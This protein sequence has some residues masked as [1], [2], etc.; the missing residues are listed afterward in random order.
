MNSTGIAAGSIDSLVK[1]DRS[2]IILVY[3]C[4][5]KKGFMNITIQG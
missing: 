3:I 5:H 4:E 2:G 1:I